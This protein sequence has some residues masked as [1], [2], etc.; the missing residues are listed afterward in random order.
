MNENFT[1]ETLYRVYNDYDGSYIQI[2]EDPD[3]LGLVVVKYTGNPIEG[4]PDIELPTMPTKKARLL[5]KAINNLC[6]IL[7]TE[8]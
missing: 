6:D 3:G 2:N 8:G 4:L 5:A 7:E 1:L